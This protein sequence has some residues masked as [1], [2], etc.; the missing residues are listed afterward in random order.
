MIVI[1]KRNRIYASPEIC[2]QSPSS[3]LAVFQGD[4]YFRD[5]FEAARELFIEKAKE[6][7]AELSYFPVSG[8]LGNDVAVLRGGQN[9]KVLLHTSGVH[10]IGHIVLMSV[11]ITTYTLASL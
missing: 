8:D 1:G 7:G 11:V 2:D 3:D 10:G 5:T 4:C 6:I 9:G